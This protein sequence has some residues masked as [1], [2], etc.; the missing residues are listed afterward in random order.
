M[1][2][3]VRSS[4]IKAAVVSGFASLNP[5]SEVFAEFSNS[6]VIDEN[7]DSSVMNT[8]LCK[9]L[10]LDLI[11]QELQ[12]LPKELQ[13][14]VQQ[15]WIV[16]STLNAMTYHAH[17]RDGKVMSGYLFEELKELAMCVSRRWQSW[18]ASAY[19]DRLL[20]QLRL[21]RRHLDI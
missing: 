4:N 2:Y 15:K 17:I 6:I 13:G 9:S 19:P 11:V 18:Q 7:V 14:N 12:E 3:T 8:E 1:T 5:D 16:Y 21:Y 20:D 10:L